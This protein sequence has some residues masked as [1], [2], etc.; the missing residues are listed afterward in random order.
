MESLV[1]VRFA[2]WTTACVVMLGLIACGC[3]QTNP[4]P[5]RGGIGRLDLRIK[6]EANLRQ[7]GVAYQ[8]ALTTSPPRG[9]EDLKAYLDNAERILTSP[10]DKKPYHIVWGVDPSRLSTPTAETIIAW[11]Q[12]PD[13]D[14][15]RVVLMADMHTCKYLTEGEFA[16]TT[17]AKGN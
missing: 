6:S 7:I 8:A 14:G 11:E 4:A 13:Q 3:G 15:G 17:K 10:R 9:P 2:K 12:T 1:S 16:S 5:K